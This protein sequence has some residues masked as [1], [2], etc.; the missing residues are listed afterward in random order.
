[1]ADAMQMLARVI[2][3]NETH[4]RLESYQSELQ[5]IAQLGISFHDWV[6]NKLS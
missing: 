1:M 5:V 4:R 3:I 2:K 6:V